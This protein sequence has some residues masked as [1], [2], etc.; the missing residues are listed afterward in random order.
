MKHSLTVVVQ[1]IHVERSDVAEIIQTVDSLV[2]GINVN[3]VFV[4]E[5]SGEELQRLQVFL[6]SLN[7]RHMLLPLCNRVLM[8]KY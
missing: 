2:V 1:S 6:L 8:L 3:H 5:L 4:I 7:T